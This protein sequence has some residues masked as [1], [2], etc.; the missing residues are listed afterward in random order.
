MPWVRRERLLG[1]SGR[2]Y[3]LGCGYAIGA[4]IL[5]GIV[6]ELLA[7]ILAVIVAEVHALSSPQKICGENFS[8]FTRTYVRIVRK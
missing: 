3:D 8:T 2:E 5:A 4:R 7:V 1:G 6:A